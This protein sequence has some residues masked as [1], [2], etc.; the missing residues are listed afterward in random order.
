MFD[1]SD[2]GEED[3]YMQI[4]DLGSSF[5]NSD[6]RSLSRPVSIPCLTVFD[7]GKKVP[8]VLGLL[9]QRPITIN[10]NGGVARQV[11]ASLHYLFFFK[12]YYCSLLLIYSIK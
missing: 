8:L 12:H 6:P 5:H 7:V 9:N 4:M 1:D 11:E 10:S 3:S 2:L